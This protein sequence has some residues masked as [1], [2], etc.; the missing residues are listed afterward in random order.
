MKMG[1]DCMVV[2]DLLLTVYEVN[3]VM[4]KLE[5]GGIAITALHRDIKAEP[6]LFFVYFGTNDDPAKPACGPRTW[7]TK[8]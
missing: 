4:T 2:G 3:P 6:R 5:Q 1:A 7:S 8:P